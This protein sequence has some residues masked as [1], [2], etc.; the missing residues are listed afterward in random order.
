MSVHEY[1]L[2]F[3]KSS[4]YTLYLVSDPRDKM[5]RFVMGLSDDLQEEFHFYMLHYSMN[6]VSLMFYA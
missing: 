3:T 6:I 1:S 2:K 4:K 5:N